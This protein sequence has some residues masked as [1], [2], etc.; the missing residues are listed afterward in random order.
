MD[1]GCV[2]KSGW[3]KTILA[4]LFIDRIP[5]HGLFRRLLLL[6]LPATIHQRWPS[7]FHHLFRRFRGRSGLVGSLSASEVHDELCAEEKNWGKGDPERDGIG[8]GTVEEDVDS[9]PESC[10]GWRRNSDD[11]R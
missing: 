1:V 5:Y 2:G 11:P 3:R 9:L 4:I 10:E 7:S 6:P 8:V